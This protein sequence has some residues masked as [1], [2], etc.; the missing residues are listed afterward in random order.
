VDGQ[1]VGVGA[2]ERLPDI[3]IVVPVNAQGDFRNV[4]A[5][6]DDLDRY[7][8]PYELETIL[9]VNNYPE[10]EAPAAVASLERAGV[11]VLT[12]PKPPRRTGEAVVLAARM[13]GIRAARACCVVNFD[14]D[15]RIP[16]CTA[17]LN[18]YAEVFQRGASAAYTQVGHHQVQ[19]IPSVMLVLGI[20]HLSRWFKRVLL[21]IP[22]TRGSNYA[23]RR[24]LMVKFFED[25]LL[26]DDMNVG[27][28]FK[29][30][31]GRV[32][33]ASG[34][35]FRVLTSGRMFRPGWTWIVP[36]F[37]YRLRYNLRVL[38]VRRGVARFTGRQDDPVRVYMNNRPVSADDR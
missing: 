7:G 32:A 8:G 6:L 9:V 21:R 37:L 38:P 22:A 19:K 33:Y 11:A 27:P 14:S 26:A 4:R 34:R 12:I 36:Y 1:P 16:N 23:V 24:D 18:W 15:C 5:L 10:G 28:T 2:D 13:P 30:L 29:K 17:L 20:H 3:S 25:G 31:G 35:D